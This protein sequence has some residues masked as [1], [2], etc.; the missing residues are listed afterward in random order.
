MPILTGHI[1]IDRSKLPSKF[2]KLRVRFVSQLVNNKTTLLM[3]SPDAGLDFEPI[4]VRYATGMILKLGDGT[5]AQSQG[6]LVVTG[7]RLIGMV[8]DG[9]VGKAALSQSAGTVYAFAV[10]LDDIGPVE[11]KKNWRGQPVEA[12]IRSKEGQS[13]SFVLQVFSVVAVLK[14]DGHVIPTSLPDFLN[15]LTPEGRRN[16]QKQA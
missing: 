10:D 9:A 13:P 1:Q 6:Q 14:N 4:Y 8:T 7:Q 2:D 15:R 12:V 11:I 5:V 16:L 3:I